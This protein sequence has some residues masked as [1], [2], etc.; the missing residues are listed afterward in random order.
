MDKGSN[1][2]D[3]FSGKKRVYRKKAAMFEPEFVGDSFAGY[4]A[5]SRVRTGGGRS[6]SVTCRFPILSTSALPYCSSNGMISVSDAILLCQKA[7]AN[8]PIFKN[9]IDMMSELAN[10]ELYLKGGN[11]ESREFFE[12][13]F[14][15]IKIWKIKDQF[16]R[17][18]FRSGSVFFYRI[19]GKMSVKDA[20]R[21]KRNYSEAV[22]R[23]IDIPLKYVLL[24]PQNISVLDS[25]NFANPSYYRIITK[26]ELS[27]LKNSQNPDDKEVYKNIP[28]AIKK[29]FDGSMGG[30]QFVEV[31]PSYFHP[32]FYKKQDY[33][34][35]A[36]PM[37]Y[38]VLDSIELK[39]AM[40]K[41]DS[42]IART[43]EYIILLVTM[44]A[45]PEDG[46]V[47][48]ESLNM[49]KKA[50]GSGSQVG[51][52][53]V[54]DYTTEAQFVI[55]DLNKVMG[56]GKYKVVNEDISNG[57]MNIF[58]GDNKFANMM[59]KLKVFIEKLNDAQELF[60]N[61]FLL[62]EIKRISKEMGFKSYPTP[63]FIKISLDDQTNSHRIVTQLMQMGMLTPKDGLEAIEKG[64]LPEYDTLY[65]N[66]NKY[67]K[68]RDKGLFEPVLGGP[69]SNSKSDNS[70]KAP[71]D[72]GRPPGTKAPQTSKKVSP[73]GTSGS[74]EY[75]A[76]L[77]A[78]NINKYVKLKEKISSMDISDENVEILANLIVTNESPD[79]WEESVERYIE[80]P[81]PPNLEN[82]LEI[83]DISIDKNVDIEI[84]AIYFHSRK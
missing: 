42:Y 26:Q 10:S 58:F 73:I 9:S 67:R 8:V 16:F 38:P 39:L 62:P 11:N 27:Q 18:C 31:D 32:I 69:Y 59:G 83:N 17:E 63:G 48:P 5:P 79:N 20:K 6:E 77:V 53:L 22:K 84:A 78:D 33:E 47:N 37:G 45:K 13:W 28:D 41:A 52:V 72:G 21:L 23:G 46:G 68:D 19:D 43:V 76:N 61:D 40:Q 24:N 44:G 15:K 36:V 7:Y 34:P 35:F 25:P 51:R 81:L 2:P 74:L 3:N 12:A 4:D 64:V 49:L 75:D 56:E 80:D 71:N 65:E 55:P 57:L 60:I 66:Q 29:I 54:S 50:F 14:N 70:S 30:N 82:S 1:K